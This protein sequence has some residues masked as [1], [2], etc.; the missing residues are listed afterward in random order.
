MMR[1]SAP[2]KAILFGEHAVV[3]GQPALAIPLTQVQA[4]AA[5]QPGGNE[6]WIEAPDVRR[7]YTLAEA[8]PDDA[9]AAAVRLTCARAGEAA[10]PPA[11]LSLASRIP[12]ASGLGSGAAACTAV[13]R[14]TAQLLGCP[15][16]DSDVS[17]IVFET[18]KMLHG[19]P[20]GIDNTVV[21]F[22]LPVYFVRGQPPVPLRAALSFQLLIGDTGVASPTKA[23][24]ADVRAAW[25]KDPQR[26]QK[27]FQAVGDLAREARNII[28][29]R[30]NRP[31]AFL[32]ELMNRNHALL[33][34]LDV[35]SPELENLVTAARAAGA[36]GAKLSGAGRGGSMLALVTP[37]SEAAVRKALEQAG[38]QRV[39]GTTITP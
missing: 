2:G 34:E 21:A 38:A 12:I 28:E 27:I 20:S 24:V 16:D 32:G 8:A 7:R 23:A 13:V 33:R 3:Y 9:L 10:P 11:V 37:A 35:S 26:Y 19:T 14:A 4:T 15:L 1:A 30:G 5:I 25:Q 36:L 6:F 31:A 18:E 39:M 29:G 22:G 17:A